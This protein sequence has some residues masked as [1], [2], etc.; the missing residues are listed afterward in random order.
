MSPAPIAISPQYPTLN[1]RH[2]RQ[3]DAASF[4][5]RS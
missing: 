3:A 4:D 2:V 1:A 5:V